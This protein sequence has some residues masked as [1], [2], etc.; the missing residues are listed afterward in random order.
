MTTQDSSAS[1]LAA[2]SSSL[3]A[4]LHPELYF[5]SHLAHSVRPSSSRV[6]LE[7][8]NVDLN[9]GPV[10]SHAS[11]S[12]RPD[13]VP[14]PSA[15]A[16]IGST[17]VICKITASIVYPGAAPASASSPACSTLVPTLNLTPLSSP[18]SDFKSGAP[19]TFAQF[20]TEKLFEFLDSSM[21]FDPS[22]LDIPLEA[23]AGEPE[24]GRKVRAKWCLFADCSVIGFDGALLETSML[25][26]VAALRQV[27][28]PRAYFSLDEGFVVASPSDYWSL[29]EGMDRL[30]LAFGFGLY[31]G[32]LLA[33]PSSFEAD[34]CSSRL[35][36]NLSYPSSADTS[37]PPV[38]TA[39]HSTGPLRASNL[40][41]TS[42]DGEVAED[43]TVIERCAELATKH[44]KVIRD[45]LLQKEKV[46]SAE[47]AR[48]RAQ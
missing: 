48:R 3:L 10:S 16:K 43:E 14:S 13:W 11:S 40:R 12:K 31:Q 18:S 5:S 19:S 36:L 27:W 26:I 47:V 29:A 42:Q 9:L 45:L 44:G 25:A 38:L 17:T 41:A 20:T 21:P 7:F 28:L 37:E 22:V 46:A 6:P 24:D 39:L 23:G 15:L 4:R 30:P 34:L 35:L 32:T 8:P 1:T 2:A 33:T